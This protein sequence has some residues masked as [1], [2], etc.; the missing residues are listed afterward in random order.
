MS[1]YIHQLPEWPNF[2]WKQERV[3]ERLVS[4]HY[5]Q[6]RLLGRM[7]ALGFQLQEEVT[8]DVVKTSEVEG[9]N[10]DPEQV[11]SSV[12]RRLGMDIAGLRPSDRYVDG[13]VEMM[14]DA[15][16]N[17]EHSLTAER[18]FYWHA[19]LFPDADSGMKK[20]KAG[21]WRGDEHGAMQVVSGS[22]GRERVHF[23]APDAGRLEIEI[24]AF[25]GWF[26]GA[27]QADWVVKAALAHLWFVTIH[28]FDDGN[29]RIARAI[30]DL[31]LARSENTWDRFYSMSSQ[32]RQERAAYYNILE[33]TQRGEMD[34][35][36]WMEWFF[37]CL[38]R[39][40]EGSES[41]LGGV[42]QKAK[43][44]ESAGHI[45][46]NDRQRKML[47][48]LWEGF[49]GALTT[50]KWAA[51]TKSSQDTAGRDIASLVELGVLARN[52]QGGR[53]TSYRIAQP[54]ERRDF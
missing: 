42:L 13:V 29:G 24:Q 31:A 46:L 26:N 15:T 5:A 48:L 45:S 35:T 3:A 47:N 43:F 7:E 27:N 36:P 37:D 9:E 21:E 44:W 50:S 1:S 12:A 49:Q 33:Q 51:L 14:T 8:A 19:A 4:I 11:R 17:Y 40:I 30:A 25:L 28:P 39:A 52:P 20:L 2:T 10:L 18:L 32:I 41:M 34:V 54:D 6:G 22:L 53:G 38:R 23:Q 16:R